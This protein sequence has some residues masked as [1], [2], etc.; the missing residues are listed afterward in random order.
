MVLGE[1]DVGL[2][3]SIR[4][5]KSVDLGGVDV[6]QSL[7]SLLDLVL[8]G[9]KIYDKNECVVVLDVLHGAL[10]GKGVLQNGIL[11]G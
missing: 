10:S 3:L 1:L 11:N 7:N 8:V 6:V 9:A 5:D 4:S 2:F